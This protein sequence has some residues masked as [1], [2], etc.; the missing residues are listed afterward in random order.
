M[1]EHGMIAH[2]RSMAAW[3]SGGTSIER[4][5]RLALWLFLLLCSVSCQRRTSDSRQSE[6]GQPVPP[7]LSHCTRV[8]IR[9]LPTLL[10][11]RFDSNL[12]KRLL[13]PTELA[14]VESL[15]PIVVEQEDRI[16]ALAQKI[17]LGTYYDSV[18]HGVPGQYTFAQVSCYRNDKRLESFVIMQGP[19]IRT[20]SDK[21]F[22]YHGKNLELLQ[23]TTDIW[24]LVLRADCAV[25]LLKIGGKWGFR[26]A[27]A[28]M[29]PAADTWCDATV[30]EFLGTSNSPQY[31]SYAM[32]R[33]RCPAAGEGKCHYAMNPECRSDSPPD[34]VFLFET[35]AGWNQHGG[36]ELFTFDNHDPKGGLVLLN[37]GHVKFIRTEE[38]LKQ[39]RWK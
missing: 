33:F 21:W 10:E 38:E 34:T 15:D 29:R 31:V 7:D 27:R 6:A 14:H 25:H 23:I 26:P 28:A 19:Y 13:S 22:D 2:V 4:C 8:E 36:P 35:R 39:L 32:G 12:G 5:F 30:R 18:Q 24:P 37:D 17:S 11:Y 20:E 9:Y 3:L 1:W 16:K